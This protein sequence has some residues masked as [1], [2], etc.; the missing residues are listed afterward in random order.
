M[1]IV[2]VDKKWRIVL[3]RRLRQKISLRKNQHLNLRFEKDFIILKTLKRQE[4]RS[5]RDPV[6]D[7]ILKNPA[8]A[9]PKKIKKIDLEKIEEEMWLP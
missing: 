3:P 1:T 6:L 5:E 7:D 2:K 9:D 4:S 8:H